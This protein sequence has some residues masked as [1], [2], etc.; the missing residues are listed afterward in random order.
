LFHE[1]RIEEYTNPAGADENAEYR[2]RRAYSSADQ[3]PL[4]LDGRCA[5]TI[6]VRELLP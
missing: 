5:A 3:I 1:Q 6:S 2:Q 4:M